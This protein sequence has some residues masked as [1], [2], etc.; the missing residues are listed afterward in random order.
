MVKKRCAPIAR[1]ACR[2]RIA[3]VQTNVS[4]SPA[5]VSLFEMVPP[6]QRL[7]VTSIKTLATHR[8]T[9]NLLCQ[10]LDG[11]QSQTATRV[12]EGDG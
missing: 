6:V 2:P 10:P 9:V 12:Y 8:T 4:Q 3:G 1:S 5:L 11:G 7:A